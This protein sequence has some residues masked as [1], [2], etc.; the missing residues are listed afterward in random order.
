ML[1]ST[2]DHEV[3]RP[4]QA[5]ACVPDC[6]ASRVTIVAVDEYPGGVAVYLVIEALSDSG[7]PQKVLA[8]IAWAFLEPDLVKAIEEGVDTSEHLAGYT[9]WKRIA[10][11]GQAGVWTCGVD[12]IVET[13]TS[14]GMDS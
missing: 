9:E 13:V 12:K 8:P 6:R 11:E 3:L 5:W 10:N 7:S 2:I 14:A 1:Y 4:G